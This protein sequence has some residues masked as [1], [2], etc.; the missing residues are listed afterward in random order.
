LTENLPEANVVICD[1]LTDC[2]KTVVISTF[3]FDSAMKGIFLEPT[4]YRPK[5][6]KV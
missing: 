5:A 6:K 2:P 4:S 1:T 3:V